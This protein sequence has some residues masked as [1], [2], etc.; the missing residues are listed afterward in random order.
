MLSILTSRPY[1][2]PTSSSAPGVST[3]LL[4]RYGFPIPEPFSS[5]K[6]LPTPIIL[7]PWLLATAHTRHTVRTN[8]SSTTRSVPPSPCPCLFPSCL[9]RF[10]PPSATEN[11]PPFFP[12]DIG[13]KDVL[14]P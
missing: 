12:I 13:F 7:L 1:P 2:C 10:P 6:P 8:Y 9:P 11:T 3:T 14:P 4:F 5:S